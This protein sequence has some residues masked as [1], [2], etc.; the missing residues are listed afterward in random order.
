[1]EEYLSPISGKMKWELLFEL[2]KKKSKKV[3]SCQK[4]LEQMSKSPQYNQQAKPEQCSPEVEGVNL[5]KPGN[6][7][8]ISANNGVM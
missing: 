2:E 7:P 8:S 5:P 4:L 6:W 1:M 3:K